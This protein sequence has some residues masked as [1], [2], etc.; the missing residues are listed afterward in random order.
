MLNAFALLIASA[1]RRLVC[2]SQTIG[3][4]QSFF[5]SHWSIVQWNC[6]ECT[7]RNM[8]ARSTVNELKQ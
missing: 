2:K 7:A 5:G 3:Q 6:D 1:Q 8:V 4:Q